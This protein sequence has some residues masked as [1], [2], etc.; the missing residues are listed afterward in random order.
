[1]SNWRFTLTITGGSIYIEGMRSSAVIL[2]VALIFGIIAPSSLSL[3]AAKGGQPT[4]GM[5][6]VCRSAT[7][8][9]SSNVEMPCVSEALCGQRHSSVI[10][11]SEIRHTDFTQILLQQKNERPPKA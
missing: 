4:I 11:F 9:L 7:P 8:A 1:M 6:N 3:S 5:L 10:A 2:L